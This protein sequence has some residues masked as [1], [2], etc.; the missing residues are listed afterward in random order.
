MYPNTDFQEMISNEMNNHINSD[1]NEEDILKNVNIILRWVDFSSF[2]K[3]FTSFCIKKLSVFQ[4]KM[5]KFCSFTHEKTTMNHNRNIF[6]HHNFQIRKFNTKVMA[7]ACT[8]GNQVWLNCLD[9]QSGTVCKIYGIT[10]TLL[11]G[12][13]WK[14]IF[15]NLYIIMKT[16]VFVGQFIA[17]TSLSLWLQMS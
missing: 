9:Q 6:Q 16:G 3:Q 10:M 4:F 5:Y 12:Q 8:V 13:R 17:L 2:M 7:M 11:N 14:H 1:K 15:A